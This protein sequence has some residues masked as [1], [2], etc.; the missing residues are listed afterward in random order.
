MLETSA[1]KSSV[2]ISWETFDCF[3]GFAAAGGG[4]WTGSWESC[5]FRWMTG[6]GFLAVGGMVCLGAAAAPISGSSPTRL[7]LNALKLSS[8]SPVLS[9]QRAGLDAE[10]AAAWRL[11][12]EG[13]LRFADTL[14]L[15]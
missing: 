7:A 12:L 3:F 2:N 15:V 13:G 4:A 14:A 8:S 11:L 5:G 10:A 9:L 1:K 6:E